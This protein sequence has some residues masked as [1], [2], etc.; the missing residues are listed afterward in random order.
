M[1]FPR[2][3]SKQGLADSITHAVAPFTVSIIG[4]LKTTM[5]RL[6]GGTPTSPRKISYPIPRAP[7]LHGLAH[8][9]CVGALAGTGGTTV[10]CHSSTGSGKTLA[11]FRTRY[12]K[13]PP[14]PF[15]LV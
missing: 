12:G 9:L 8:G 7:H 15:L 14:P 11:G 1:R 13:P 6:C 3:A 10:G 2:R 4:C 5:V